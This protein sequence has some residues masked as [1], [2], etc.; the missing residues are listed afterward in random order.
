MQTTDHYSEALSFLRATAID[1]YGDPDRKVAVAQVHATLALAEQQRVA[2]LIA[3]A[4][5][6]HRHLGRAAYRAL[7]KVNLECDYDGNKTGQDKVSPDIAR[8]LRIETP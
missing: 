5:S 3:L 2:N 6:H 8:A 4:H 1:T 7:A